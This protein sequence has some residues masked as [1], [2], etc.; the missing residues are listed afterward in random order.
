M[1][2][3]K[4]IAINGRGASQASPANVSG[5][6]IEVEPLQITDLVETAETNHLK[7]VIDWSAPDNG[8]S[9]ILSYVI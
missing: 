3:A 4:I 8:S 7:V 9:P 2:E 1:V 5:A 6:T